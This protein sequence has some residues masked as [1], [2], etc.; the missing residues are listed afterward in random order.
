MGSRSR[1]YRGAETDSDVRFNT[2]QNSP[3]HTF[4][5][6]KWESQACHKYERA[7]VHGSELWKLGDQPGLWRIGEIPR[8]LLGPPGHKMGL[9]IE[10]C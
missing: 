9:I 3:I 5:L 8:I 1:E 6:Q 4:L 2:V 10:S 7:Q